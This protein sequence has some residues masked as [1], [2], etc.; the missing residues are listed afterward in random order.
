MDNKMDNNT[1]ELCEH[2]S[3]DGIDQ[4]PMDD[5]KVWRCDE[6]DALF[7]SVPDGD[8]L[9][10]DVLLTEDEAASYITSITQDN[11]GSDTNTSI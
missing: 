7:R 1:P 5:R 6:C 4:A 11:N 2:D 9:Y 10:H 3:A 8:C